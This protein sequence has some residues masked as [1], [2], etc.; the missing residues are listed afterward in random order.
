ME[1]ENIFVYVTVLDAKTVSD[2]F[3]SRIGDRFVALQVTI[4][5][6]SDEFQYLLHDV[7]LDLKEIFVKCSSG[8][9]SAT[10][11]AYE[12]RAVDDQSDENERQEPN[13]KRKKGEQ[14]QREDQSKQQAVTGRCTDN[15]FNYELS[16][17]ELSLLRGVSEK[18]QGQDKRNMVLRIFRGVGTVAA[19]LIGVASFG[20][21]FA[22]SVAVFN[23]PLI[24][25]YMDVFPDYTINQMNRLNDTAYRSNTLVPKQQAKVL[26]AFVPQ[27]MFLTKEQRKQFK[28]DPTTLFADIDFRRTQAVVD[29]N[30]I[31]ELA[32]MPPTV[33]S[34]QFEQSELM[35]FQ[36]NAPVV[37]GFVLGRFLQG[38]R[39]S[40][41]NQEADG[42]TIELEGTPTDKRLNF[43]IKSDG[44]VPPGT[45]LDFEVAND[46]GVQNISRPVRYSPDRPTVS[47]IDPAEGERGQSDVA[48]NITGTGFIP[49][50][51]RVI[52]QR[53]SG[54]RVTG[55]NVTSATTLEATLSIASNAPIKGH[56]IRIA[57][58][59]AQ[60]EAAVTFTVK[61]AP[62]TAPQ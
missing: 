5:N 8:A 32:K 37:K 26:V 47:D 3:G 13:Q 27:A 35:K 36:D 53:G 45:M 29:G 56:E 43:I 1:K 14:K 38:S 12:S 33:T 28:D 54:I 51:T 22:E 60:S 19:G 24:S 55:V 23:G 44:P 10:R 52:P 31:V 21:S 58:S 48:V 42:M 4:T 46:E 39:I 17:L 2:V 34:V 16:S 61:A 57:N 40:L 9:P 7:S 59:S 50:M 25:G 15:A 6:R 49:G 62:E 18:G 20:P 11:L 41:L 30:F